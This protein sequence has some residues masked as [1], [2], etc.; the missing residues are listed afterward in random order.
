MPMVANQKNPTFKVV[1]RKKLQSGVMLIEVM[2]SILIF[3]IGILGLVG[4]QTVAT[5]NATNAED[6]TIAATLANDMVAQM[7]IKKTA[8]PSSSSISGDITTWKTNVTGSSLPN[9]TGAVTRTNGITSVTVTWKAPSKKSTDNANQYV[10][11]VAI[12]E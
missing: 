8:N 10:T 3:S 5:Q 6:R 1:N 4:L 11:Q 2:V 12:P 9:A 7:W